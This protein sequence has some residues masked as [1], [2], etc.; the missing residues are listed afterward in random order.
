[1]QPS[2]FGVDGCF[3]EDHLFMLG[4]VERIISS[5]PDS[6][7]KGMEGFYG[8]VNAV[9]TIVSMLGGIS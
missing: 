2:D 8:G 1:M 6:L 5:H 9:L 3:H 4:I 7:D